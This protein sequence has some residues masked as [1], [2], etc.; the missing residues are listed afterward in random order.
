MTKDELGQSLLNYM[1]SFDQALETNGFAYSQQQIDADRKA[2]EDLAQGKQDPEA[3]VGNMI[4]AKNV[5]ALFW[6][7]DEAYDYCENCYPL[8]AALPK[9]EW[10]GLTDDE[11]FKTHK[12]VD[13]MQ[14]L[15]F[16]KAIEAKL[17]KLNH[18]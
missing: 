4:E 15:T 14:Y 8:Y 11:I 13:S 2:M 6:T 17:R 1:I 7:S 3:W 9:R 12:Q 5:K 10:V 18:D 16:G